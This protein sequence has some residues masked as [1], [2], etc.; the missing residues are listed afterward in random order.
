MWQ[1]AVLVSQPTHPDLY[2]HDTRQ[3]ICNVCKNEF[4]CHPPTRAELLASFTGPELAALIEE[5]CFIGSAE[6][7]SREL[8]RQ[9]ASFPGIMR[10]GIVCLN[11]IRH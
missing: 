3:R 11:W 4:T 6:N 5:R 2:D 7:F 8:E 1:R 9:V 10:E